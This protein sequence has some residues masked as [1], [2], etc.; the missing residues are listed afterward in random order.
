[1]LV[2]PR[3][4]RKSFTARVENFGPEILGD[5]FEALP[6]E[7]L[8]IETRQAVHDQHAEDRRESGKQDGQF[9]HDREK[10]GD[11]VEI[12]RL[13][14]DD[15]R[16]KERRGPEFQAHSGQEAGETP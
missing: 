4:S 10:C 6:V 14:R 9:K 5:F 2:P 15:E 7:E 3:D 1:M 12:G 8:V 16:V 11:G 13:A